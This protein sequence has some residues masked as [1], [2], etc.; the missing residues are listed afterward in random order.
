MAAP[1]EARPPAGRCA[2]RQGGASL[3]EVMVAVVVLSIGLL[4]LGLMISFAVQMPKVSGYRMI[5]TNI[6][7]SQIER[8]RANPAGVFADNYSVALNYDGSSAAITDPGACAYPTCTPATLATNDIFLAQNAARVELP[9]GGIRVQCSNPS[10]GV[11]ESCS[12]VVPSSS[13]DIL[14]VWREPSNNAI[15]PNLSTSDQ[16]PQDSAF[17]ALDPAPRCLLVRFKI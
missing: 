11:A 10:T 8:M 2:P 5:A 17:Q 14:I 6:A 1:P 3:I 16:C 13:G 12:T 4:S 9:A 15:T 7:A